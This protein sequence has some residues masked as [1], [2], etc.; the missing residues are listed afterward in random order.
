MG[1]KGEW[2]FVQPQIGGTNLE[3]YN[4][5]ELNDDFGLN[6]NMA[7]YRSYDPS[8]GRWGQVD[9]LAE[10]Y[11]TMSSY[12]GMGNNPIR[13]KD[14]KG[15]SL[16]NAY[17]RYSEF[18]TLDSDLKAVITN[19][20]TRNERREARRNLRR[21][22]S[23]I[24]NYNRYVIVDDLITAFETADQDEYD[25]VNNLMFNGVEVDV[26]VRLSLESSSEGGAQGLI[27]YSYDP[28][29]FGLV[30]QAGQEGS[31]LEPR[32]IVNN[33]INV[34]L[35]Q[36]GNDLGTLA[37]EFGDAIFGVEQPATVYKQH[38]DKLP[39]LHKGTTLFSFEY[40]KF[41]LGRTTRPLSRTF[42]SL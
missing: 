17:E 8:I 21:N 23:N 35:Y 15:D 28:N 7:F 1:I 36:R 12:N 29:S 42:K 40:E 4:G 31:H 20:T 3:Q 5:I 41:I 30:Q 2:K 9:P 25:K 11:L 38:I 27:V 14:P 39:Y 19:S 6:W 33:K 34:T 18:E 24:L 37:N 13:N 10:K 16:I 32:A 22:Y 26:E